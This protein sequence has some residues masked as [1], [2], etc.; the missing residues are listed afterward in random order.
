MLRIEC[1]FC[2]VRD[3]EEF[4]YGGPSHVSRPGPSCGATEW[5]DY[6][7][8]R[9]NPKGVHYE[10]WCHSFGCCRWFNVARDTV[11]HDVLAV[12][13]MGEPKPVLNECDADRCAEPAKR[14]R[15]SAAS[16]PGGR[17]VPGRFADEEAGR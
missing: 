6:L 4:T 14:G 17:R 12:Y 8:H 2:G 16:T 11:T 13:S 15:T 9:D 10:R 5:A 1:T 3:E 7:F